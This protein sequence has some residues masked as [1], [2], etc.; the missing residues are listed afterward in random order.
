MTTSITAATAAT[1]SA[2]QTKKSESPLGN[3]DFE[4]FLRMLTTQLKNQDPMNPMEGSEFA[5]QL[6]TFS[7]VEQQAHSNKLLTQIANQLG[8]G[9]L[10]QLSQ[11]LGKEVRTTAPVWFGSDAITLDI[12]PD[13]R[14][15]SVI[16][17]TQNAHG[18]ELSREEI[19]TGAGQVDWF[20]RDTVGNKVADGSYAF[21]IES[22]LNGEKIAESDVGAYSRV[23]GAETTAQG[24]RLVLTGG[25]TAMTDEVDAIREPG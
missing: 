2:T 5:V 23:T 6:A 8:G 19:G 1:T 13:S 14:A 7:G 4:T 10:T 15:D 9:G 17:V 11:Y 22:Y 3:A 25:A 18:R 12:K 24:V 16:L 20:G 21:R